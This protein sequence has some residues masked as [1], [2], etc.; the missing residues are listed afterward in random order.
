MSHGLCASSKQLMSE[1]VEALSKPET[2]KTTYY[3]WAHLDCGSYVY[4]A[5][6]IN[7]IKNDDHK[8]YCWENPNASRGYHEHECSS[9]NDNG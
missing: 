2:P 5:G 3:T 1:D 8:G 6:K 4:Y 9:C 7:F